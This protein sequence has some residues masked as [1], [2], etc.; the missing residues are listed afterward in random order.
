MYDSQSVDRVRTYE[1]PSAVQAFKDFTAA[2][3]EKI[4]SFEQQ[5]GRALSV[6]ERDMIIQNENP[7]NVLTSGREVPAATT[8]R[9]ITVG[10]RRRRRASREAPLTIDSPPMLRRK[11]PP[12][13]RPTERSSGR[14][15]SSP[16]WAMRGR[17][18]VRRLSFRRGPS[19]CRRRC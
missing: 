2:C 7:V 4:A 16:A 6:D 12:R 3:D 14:E 13:M 17:S 15:G 5:N 1:G 11:S 8:V 10:V 19:G 18:G 9:P